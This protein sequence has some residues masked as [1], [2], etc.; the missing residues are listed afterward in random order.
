MGSPF[1]LCSGLKN[2]NLHA[3]Y[4]DTFKHFNTDKIC[5]FYRKLY[6]F[7]YVTCFVINLIPIGAQS[8]GLIL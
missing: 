4:D 8:H 3:K 1:A 2:I 5:Y 6:K 7:W